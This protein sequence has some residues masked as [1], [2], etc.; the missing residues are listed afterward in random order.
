[1]GSLK[2]EQKKLAKKLV[3]KDQ[4]DKIETIAGA[5]QAFIKN[6][7]ISSIVVCNYQDMQ[8]IESKYAVAESNLPYIKGYRSFREGPAVIDAYS[9]LNSKPSILMVEGHGIAHLRKMGLASY[10][11]IALDI[12]TIGIARNLLHGVIRDNKI[13]IDNEIRGEL[14]K[15]K[16]KARPLYISPGNKI[17]LATSLEIVKKCIKTPHKMPEPLHLAHKYA[18]KI[19]NQIILE[20]KN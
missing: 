4:F 5:D 19:K 13:Y 15:T 16:D 2:E 20:N 9:K 10:I 12:P 11:G 14:L 17:T 8:L 1:M 7:I 3:I 18:K 6:K